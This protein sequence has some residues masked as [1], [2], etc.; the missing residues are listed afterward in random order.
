MVLVL[1]NERKREREYLV[2]INI[3]IGLTNLMQLIEFN[4]GLENE[5][6]YLKLYENTDPL[7]LCGGINYP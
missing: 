3:N 5:R 1:F 6:L 7:W 2:Y 4:C